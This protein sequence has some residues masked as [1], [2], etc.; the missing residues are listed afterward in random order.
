MPLV[1]YKLGGSLL[2]LPDL[3][4]R[5]A[6]LF[7]QDPPLLR[8]V[9]SRRPPDRAVLVGGGS[10]ADLVRDWDKRHKL[11]ADRAHDLALAAMVLNARFI[12]FMLANSEWVNRRSSI[13]AACRR[14]A[15]AVLDARA[16][17]DEA[18]RRSGERL[19]RSWA[20][21]SDSIAAFLAIQLRASALVLIKSTPRPQRGPADAARR[22]TVDKHFPQLAKNIAVVA[23]SNL[24]ASRPR[25]ER[26]L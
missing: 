23:W 20:L 14:G 5:L 7:E 8:Q 3:D 6:V 4:R 11:G 15:I 12:N 26:W 19:P 10:A 24:R 16:L 13:G 22:G 1:L 17:L 25:I 21:T 2:T 18:E 9:S